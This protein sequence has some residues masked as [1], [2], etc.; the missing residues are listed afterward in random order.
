MPFRGCQAFAWGANPLQDIVEALKPM[1]GK[2]RVMASV[3]MSHPKMRFW[4]DQ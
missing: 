3:S 2:L 1:R 4:G